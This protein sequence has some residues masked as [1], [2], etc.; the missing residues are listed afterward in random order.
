M[1]NAKAQDY[2]RRAE[3]TLKV[4]NARSG[5]VMMELLAQVQA[6]AALAVAAE[7]L[8]VQD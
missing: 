2:F 3:E 5:A 8:D 1:A 4:A 6:Y 7:T